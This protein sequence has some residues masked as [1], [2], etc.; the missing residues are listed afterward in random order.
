MSC[1]NLPP[2][3]PLADRTSP[4][5][6]ARTRTSLLVAGLAVLQGVC[7]LFFV[8]NLA[9]QVFGW[10]SQ[11]VSWTWV[12]VVEIMATLGLILGTALG[13]AL[14]ATL[15]AE[16]QRAARRFAAAS[17][18]FHGAVVDRFEEWSLTPSERDVALFMIKGM[19]NT[20]IAA[21]RGTSE[22]TIK[23]QST[24][25]FRKAG[26]SGRAQLLGAFLDDLLDIPVTQDGTAPK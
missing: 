14:F 20:E 18:A 2:T 1:P 26:V 3:D 12:E 5:V 23:A 6:R 16:R 7:A 22:G 11:P 17:G 19:S 24:A 21:L 8:Y 13:V 25:V 4:P 15:M 10:R 9:A